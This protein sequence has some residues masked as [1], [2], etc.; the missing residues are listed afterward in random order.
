MLVICSGKPTDNL[1]DFFLGMGEPATERALPAAGGTGRRPPRRAHRAD[2]HRTRLMLLLVVVA[3]PDDESFGCG[4]L[5]AA[6]RRRWRRD[7]GA[8][9]DPR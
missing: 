7:R 8:V 3:H 2:G 6:R 4:S 5:L 1:E 9:R